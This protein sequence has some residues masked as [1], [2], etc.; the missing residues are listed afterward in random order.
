[1]F[2]CAREPA[3]A[4]T[5]E[6]LA[7]SSKRQPTRIR[8]GSGVAASK[9]V[10]QVAPVYPPLARQTPI[11]CTVR[12]HVIVGKDGRILF[13]EVLSGH[14]L[15]RQAA[16]DAV[17]QWR[18]E[19]TLLRGEP[20]EVDTTVEVKFASDQAPLAPT[21]EERPPADPDGAADDARI[22]PQLRRHILRLFEVTRF[23]EN[24]VKGGREVL[25]SLRPALE[26][27]LP[28]TP[29][30]ER[31]MDAYVGKLLSLVES[32]A[33]TERVIALYAKYFSDA[34]V[35]QLIQFYQTPVGQRFNTAMPQLFGDL[36]QLGQSMAMDRLPGIIAELCSEFPELKD[37]P[38][39]C[40]EPDLPRRS[41]L[42]R[43]DPLK[44]S[45]W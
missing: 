12:L 18:Y 37:D 20:V 19:P 21:V 8:L 3:P 6:P 27:S 32:D 1:L 5:R 36:N 10:E 2:L 26:A 17:I 15:L 41:L 11:P 43:P 25:A 9:L 23:Q 24:A 45:G 16:L 28:N 31:I 44:A 14:P 42:R 38:R 4:Q 30:R 22:D 7:A 35:L 29:S 13:L 39:F 33:Y 34:D 40:K